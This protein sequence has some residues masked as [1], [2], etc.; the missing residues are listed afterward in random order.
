MIAC[1]EDRRI[2]TPGQ[3]SPQGT[4]IASFSV[5]PT[6]Q[7]KDRDGELQEPTEW[8]AANAS[9]RLAPFGGQYV[10]K[11]SGIVL[12][13]RKPSEPW[14]DKQPAATNAGIWNTSAGSSFSTSGA[15]ENAIGGPGGSISNRIR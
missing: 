5:A 6:E 12:E 7:W 2:G 4:A 8:Y 11:S 10:H 1:C 13:G 15:P 9:I 14:E 3:T